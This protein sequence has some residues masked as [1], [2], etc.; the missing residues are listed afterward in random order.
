M[1]KTE[2]VLSLLAKQ[3]FTLTTADFVSK[4]CNVR[5]D[6]ANCTSGTWVFKFTSKEK[7]PKK[8]PKKAP[9]TAEL[10]K[11][12]QAPKKTR[13]PKTKKAAKGK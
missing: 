13:K 11:P 8:A 6:Y 1:Y 10:K 12:I 7:A 9:D 5:T 2:D 4:T 3:G